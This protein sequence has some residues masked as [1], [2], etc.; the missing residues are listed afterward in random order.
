MKTFIGVTGNV[1]VHFLF[2]SSKPIEMEF[3][4]EDGVVTFPCL[5]IFDNYLEGKLLP[6][7][8]DTPVRPVHVI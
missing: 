2:I 1:N 5:S 4:D 8:G 6:E 3:I 7:V